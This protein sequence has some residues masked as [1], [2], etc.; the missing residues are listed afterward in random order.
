[1]PELRASD[2]EEV[3]ACCI[4]KAS[5]SA[6]VWSVEPIVDEQQLDPAVEQLD[7]ARQ[8]EDARPS[9]KHGTTT[10]GFT[11]KRA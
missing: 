6:R 2:I 11:C 9:L 3:P 7:E 5:S 4:A 1:L 10:M 8:V